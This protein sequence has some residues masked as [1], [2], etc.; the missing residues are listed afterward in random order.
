MSIKSLRDSGLTWEQ[1]ASEL[2]T[3]VATA[4]RWCNKVNGN[5]HNGKG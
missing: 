2:D 3:S 4:K 1:V 5:G